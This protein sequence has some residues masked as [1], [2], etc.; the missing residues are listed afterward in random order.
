VTEDNW[1]GMGYYYF[2]HASLEATGPF[3]APPVATEN[4]SAAYK[5]VTQGAGD[6]LP[7]RDPVDQRVLREVQ[8]GTGHIIRWVREAGQQ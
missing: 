5:R 1:R 7:V 2:D 3:P 6:T 8:E 4:A